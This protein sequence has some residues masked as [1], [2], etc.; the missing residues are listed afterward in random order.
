MP[1]PRGASSAQRHELAEGIVDV[2]RHFVELRQE[3]AAGQEAEGDPPEIRE[4]RHVEADALRHGADRVDLGYPAS[5]QEKGEVGDLD[6]RDRHVEGRPHSV[7][8]ACTRHRPGHPGGQRRQGNL[9]QVAEEATPVQLL[10]LLGH[11]SGLCD[12]V[13][14]GHGVV[15]VAGQR[16]QHPR[17]LVAQFLRLALRPRRDGHHGHQRSLDLLVAIGQETA[18]P[19]R[20]ASQDHVVHRRLERPAD[21]LHVLERHGEA[22]KAFAV[23]HRTVER[24][25]W[26]REKPGR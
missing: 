14:P 17:D 12:G 15:D 3:A 24:G 20:D 10:L 6:A 4:G 18:E 25:A 21:Q 1:S 22:G 2:H 5:G 26:R 16:H 19:A 23:R 11:A 7:E 13:E 9:G 8:E